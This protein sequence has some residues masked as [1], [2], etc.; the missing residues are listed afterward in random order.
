[1]STYWEILGTYSEP[2]QRRKMEHFGKKIYFSAIFAKNSILNLWESAEYVL[3]FKY[4]RVLNI[5]K[6]LVIWPS[7]EYALEGFWIF[8]DSEYTKFLR[9]QVLQ[10]VLNM[11]EYG[12]IMPYSVVLHMPGQ[13]FAG[14]QISLWL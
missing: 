1:M 8:Q 4:V 9:L 5:R 10:K 14:F 13:R 3:R 6:S 11:P 7:S 2:C 12:W